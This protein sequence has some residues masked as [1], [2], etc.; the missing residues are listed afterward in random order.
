MIFETIL[1]YTSNTAAF[2]GT[3]AENF[4]SSFYIN[5]PGSGAISGMAQY[6]TAL[7]VV[8]G[9]IRFLGMLVLALAVVYFLWGVLQ[10][11]ISDDA[12]KREDAIKTITYGIIILFVMVSMWSLVFLIGSTFNLGS[13]QVP[14]TQVVP[15]NS[16]IR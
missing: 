7:G 12:T 5:L 13:N 4:I 15:I 8:I 16:L 3:T 6:S 1:D 10:Y 11:V 14:R 9:V 2:I